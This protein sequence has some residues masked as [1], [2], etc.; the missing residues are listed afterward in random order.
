MGRRH[1]AHHFSS[2]P[3]PSFT[4][5]AAQPTGRLAAHMLDSSDAPAEWSPWVDGHPRHGPAQLGQSSKEPRRRTIFFFM[6]ASWLQLNGLVTSAVI[7]ICPSLALPVNLCLHPSAC[8]GH[9][10]PTLHSDPK[11]SNMEGEPLQLYMSR[12]C[13]TSRQAGRRRT[14]KK[15]K[16]LLKIA[17]FSQ[18]LILTDIS[19]TSTKGNMTP[20]GNMTSRLVSYVV[21]S[22]PMTRANMRGMQSSPPTQHAPRCTPLFLDREPSPG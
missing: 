22:E 21:P 5:V 6:L 18:E 4:T 13:V 2:A 7:S 1:A 12:P 17:R 14:K 19:T 9:D 16:D 11:K 8:S 3:A 10:V 20:Q 15:K